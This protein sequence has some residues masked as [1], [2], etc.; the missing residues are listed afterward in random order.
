[1]GGKEKK[2]KAKPTQPKPSQAINPSLAINVVKPYEGDGDSKVVQESASQVVDKK[3]LDSSREALMMAKGN[4][5]YV[6]LAGEN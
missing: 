2:G 5:F 3:E 1:M 4:L 6:K